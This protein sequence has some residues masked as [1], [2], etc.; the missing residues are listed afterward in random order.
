MPEYIQKNDIIVLDY[1]KNRFHFGIYLENDLIL[2]HS[3]NK[4]SI[5]EEFSK[6]KS[7]TPYVLRHAQFNRK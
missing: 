3:R 4:K 6:Y 1:G 2:H 7:I 5:I